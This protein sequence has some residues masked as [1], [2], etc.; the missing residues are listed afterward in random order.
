M[1]IN[2]K[3]EEIKVLVTVYVLL[4]EHL[5]FIIDNDLWFNQ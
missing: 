4:E 5:L 1:T 2:N 3:V